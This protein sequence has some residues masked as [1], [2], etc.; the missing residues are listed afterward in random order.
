MNGGGVLRAGED[1]ANVAA[2]ETST[3]L[4][5]RLRPCW[6]DFIQLMNSAACVGCFELEVTISDSPPQ[7]PTVLSPAVH[8]GIGAA[9]HFPAVLG[10]IVGNWLG[11]HWAESQPTMLPLFISV[12][13]WVDQLGS[14]LI[15][16]PFTRPCQ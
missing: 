9:T 16:P 4:I 13:H 6:L 2:G 7:V 5:R 14:G 11:A 1:W 3:F 8:A 12:S 10:A 15:V